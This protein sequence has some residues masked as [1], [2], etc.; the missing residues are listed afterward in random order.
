MAVA[1]VPP[2][3]PAPGAVS[4][5]APRRTSGQAG[6]W[7]A[8]VLMEAIW[9]V[10]FVVAK[11]GL[12]YFSA[13][14]FAAVRVVFATVALFAIAAATG[15]LRR[16]TRR[17]VRDALLLGLAG[18]AAN[19]LLWI[20][21]LER[22]SP[23]HSALIVSTI[24][25][26]VLVMAA[27]FLKERISA[28]RAAGVALALGGIA[29]LLVTAPARPAAPGSPG[30]AATPTVWGDLL[31]VGTVVAWSIY[32]LAGKKVVDRAGAAGVTA[33]AHLTGV[34]FLVPVGAPAL[35]AVHW[36]ALPAGAWAAVAYVSLL[37]S[38]AAYLLY[39]WG[40]ERLGAGGVALLAYLQPPI[41]AAVSILALGEKPTLA[42]AGGAAAVLAGLALAQRA[43]RAPADS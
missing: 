9:G 7:A 10:H 2:P 25:I 26:A 17:D 4:P 33:V 31:T 39:Y 5:A 34:A 37:S 15:A 32:T 38:A 23:S 36:S 43:A 16:M 11:I 13:F 40:L 29:V 12:R 18:V 42:L 8:M 1:A 21:G 27:V 20:T 35:A 3:A 14:A 19:Q 30:A 6:V 24:P 41:A 22:T 28:R